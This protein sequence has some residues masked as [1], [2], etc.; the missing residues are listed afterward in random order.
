MSIDT[1][2]K[3]QQGFRG[4]PSLTLRVGMAREPRKREPLELGSLGR[5][6]GRVD[7]ESTR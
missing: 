4:D 1:S 2:P 5:T 7:F 6:T 3:R